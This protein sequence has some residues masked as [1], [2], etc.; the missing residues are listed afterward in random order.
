MFN[1]A[2]YAVGIPNDVTSDESY[3]KSAQDASLLMRVNKLMAHFNQPKPVDMNDE[4]YNSGVTGCSSCNLFSC[5]KN[6][7]H[8]VEGWVEDFG[9]FTTIGH[10]RWILNPTMKKTGF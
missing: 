9:N 7:Y 10:R 3:E 8:A 2:R 4:L 6:I 1:Y 5:I